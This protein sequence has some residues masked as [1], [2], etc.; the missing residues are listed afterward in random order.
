MIRPPRSLRLRA[1]AF[2]AF[3]LFLATALAEVVGL[4]LCLDGEHHGGHHASSVPIGEVA[5]PHGHDG[6]PAHHGH[7]AHDPNAA[8]PAAGATDPEEHPA[9]E[10]CRLLCA[11]ASTQ[12]IGFEPRGMTEAVTPPLPPLVG[13]DARIPVQEVRPAL[14]LHPYFLPPSQA[15]PAPHG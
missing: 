7:A 15:P 14:A 12:L 9:S 2:G 1:S 13:E 5:D 10:L 8:D 11:L 4:C 3:T 6:H